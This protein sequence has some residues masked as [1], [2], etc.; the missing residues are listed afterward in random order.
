VLMLLAIAPGIVVLWRDRSNFRGLVLVFIG[1]VSFAAIIGL[2][3]TAQPKPKEISLVTTIAVF[4]GV[5]VFALMIYATLLAAFE[6]MRYAR[7]AGEEARETKR[8]QAAVIQAELDD[9]ISRI[10]AGT[11]PDET[12]NVSGVVLRPNE[13]CCA[14]ARSVQYVVNKKH[15]S[16][17]G[18]S[19]G[20]SFRIAERRSLPC[21]R[22]QGASSYDC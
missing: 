19:H 10:G 17:V 6:A 13:R 16:Y 5:T 3:A 4:F 2:V 21:R 20:V 14:Y 18:G 11:L 15:T 7:R 8:K 12:A 9:F 22:L 1:V